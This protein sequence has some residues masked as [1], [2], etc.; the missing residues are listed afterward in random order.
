[1][2]DGLAAHRRTIRLDDCRWDIGHTTNLGPI[3][4]MQPLELSSLYLTTRKQVVGHNAWGPLDVVM[5]IT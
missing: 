5:A 3:A 4:P 1:M 2:S